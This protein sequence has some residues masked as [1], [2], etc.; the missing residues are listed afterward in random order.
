MQKLLIE[1]QKL[2]CVN[3]NFHTVDPLK[4]TCVQTVNRV[5]PYDVLDRF[6]HVKMETATW[7]K[8]I[9]SAN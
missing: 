7:G 2:Q 1:R 9:T 4:A 5:T 6:R 8:Y 3:V